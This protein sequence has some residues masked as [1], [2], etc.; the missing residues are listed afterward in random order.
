MATLRAAAR[1]ARGLPPPAVATRARASRPAAASAF[2]API[3][4]AAGRP[5]AHARPLPL[6]LPLRE[7]SRRPRRPRGTRV[8]STTASRDLAPAD[9]RDLDDPHSFEVPPPRPH[10]ASRPVGGGHPTPPSSS[11]IRPPRRRPRRSRER[12]H[13]VGP[14][15]G[16]SPSSTHP[17]HSSPLIPL[18]QPPP[19]LSFLR[20]LALSR[21]SRC[22]STGTR[23]NLDSGTPRTTARGWTSRRLWVSNLSSRATRSRSAASASTSSAPPSPRCGSTRTRAWGPSSPSSRPRSKP[24]RRWRESHRLRTPPPPPRRR[25][26]PPG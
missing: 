16:K 11:S 14:S 13:P 2:P 21:S 5:R 22:S 1:A 8:A 6:P 15:R 9:A 25:R 10:L 19:F 17:I 20:A 12:P 18:Q 4:P 7:L 3:A 24:R 26:S 23:A